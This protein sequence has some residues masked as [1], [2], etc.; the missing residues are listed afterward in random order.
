MPQIRKSANVGDWIV[1]TGSKR[2]VGSEELIYAMEITEKVPF[3]KYANDERFASKIPSKG[4]IEERGDNIYYGNIDGAWIQRPSYHGKDKMARDLSGKYVL[5]SDHFFYFGRDVVA[6][7]DE[8]HAIIKKGPGHKSNNF[9][10]KAS[11]LLF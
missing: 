7:P 9:Q 10:G 3:E 6:I 1:G 4:I 11:P 8:F 2:N 5:N